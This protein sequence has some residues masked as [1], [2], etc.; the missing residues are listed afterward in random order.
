MT[1]IKKIKLRF[2]GDVNIR[3]RWNVFI[4]MV[5]AAG[6][7]VAEGESVFDNSVTEGCVVSQ[8]PAANTSAERGTTVTLKLSLGEEEQLESGTEDSGT[9][10]TG[11]QTTE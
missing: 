7:K 1:D 4:Q 2:G 10:D 11:T 9:G 5:E 6:F 8:S 3:T